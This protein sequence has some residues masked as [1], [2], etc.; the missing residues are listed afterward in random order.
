METMTIFAL[1]I[2]AVDDRDRHHRLVDSTAAALLG[3]AVMIWM[4]S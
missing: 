3:V 1:A 4:A 2:F